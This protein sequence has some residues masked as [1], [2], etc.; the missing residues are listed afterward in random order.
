ML[1][2]H[3][4][5]FSP[6]VASC[7]HRSV[8]FDDGLLFCLSWGMFCSVGIT[9]RVN[10]QTWILLKVWRACSL[11]EGKNNRQRVIFFRNAHERQFPHTMSFSVRNQPR[12]VVRWV[13]GDGVGLG[14]C[15]TECCMCTVN[16]LC[17]WSRWMSLSIYLQ[18]TKT[19]SDQAWSCDVWRDEKLCVLFRVQ[20]RWKRT[21]ELRVEKELERRVQ[22]TMC[23]LWKKKKKTF[24]I[25]KSRPPFFVFFK[26][27]GSNSELFILFG[28]A[29]KFQVAA[30]KT[31]D[32]GK[33][34]V[35][36]VNY[37][38]TS[39]SVITMNC[40]ICFSFAHRDEHLSKH[41]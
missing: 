30:G 4:F 29:L 41:K 7:E 15:C 9:T 20:W 12:S 10:L 16:H 35:G 11:P 6:A 38:V 18:S 13:G 3:Q 5:L 23:L 39:S 19:R 17:A 40:F 22:S 32:S 31:H 37:Q 28:R 36:C 8:C 24:T 2:F 33:F 34:R 14:D 1:N 21:G 26:L 25:H 27:S